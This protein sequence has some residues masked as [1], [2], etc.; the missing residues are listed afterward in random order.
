MLRKMGLASLSLLVLAILCPVGAVSAQTG[1]GQGAR[2]RITQNVDE[3]DRVALRGNTHPEARAENDRG[4]AREDMPMEHMLLQLKRAPEQEQALV[5][6]LD[7][8]QTKGSPNFHRW[9]TAQ[10]FGGRFGVA[11]QDLDTITLWLE[12]HGFR[13]ATAWCC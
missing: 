6:F 13:K 3:G 11:K 4:A 2:A 1:F 12:S 7:E 10:E 9:I 8:L 5:A